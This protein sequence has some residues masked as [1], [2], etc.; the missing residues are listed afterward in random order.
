MKF[1]F[2]NDDVTKL[3]TGLVGLM[4]FEEGMAEGAIFQSVDKALDGLLSRLVAEEQF[5]GKK[6]QTLGFHTHGRIGPARVLLVGAGARKDFSPPDLRGFG[7]RVYKSGASASVKSVTAVMPYTE[8]VV[9]ERAAQFLAE[10]ALLAAYKFDKYLTGD[11][12]KPETVEEF[13]I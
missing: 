8:G 2:H 11:K 3:A 1:A 5:K 13:K 9:Q 12:K 6:G 10:G 4:C 7:A